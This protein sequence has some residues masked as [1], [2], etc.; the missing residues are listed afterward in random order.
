[1]IRV[2]GFLVTFI[3]A[4]DPDMRK[5]GEYALALEDGGADIIELGVP[6]S[7]PIADGPVIQRAGERALKAGTNIEKILK[8]VSV[9][10]HRTQV[11]IVLM[12]YYNPIFRYGADMFF[13]NAAEAGVDGIIIC[14]LIPE[15][16]VQLLLAPGPVDW[17]PFFFLLPPAQRRGSSVFPA[18]VQDLY[19]MF[20]LPVLP[21]RGRDWQ[22]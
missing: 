12:G 11:P 19:I 3:M 5:T 2:L 20:L 8:M 7:E 4:G 13:E 6:F 22:K 17:T 21:G 16:A 10:R 9:L 18:Y 14:D 1:M 15:E